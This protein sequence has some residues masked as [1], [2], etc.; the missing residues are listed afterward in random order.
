MPVNQTN[1]THTLESCPGYS[2]DIMAM[3]DCYNC[4]HTPQSHDQKNDLTDV[5]PILDLLGQ[6]VRGR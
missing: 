4:G 3:G 5:S 6:P 1:G 2:P